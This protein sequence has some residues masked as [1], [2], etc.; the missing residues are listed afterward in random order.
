[1]SLAIMLWEIVNFLDEHCPTCLFLIGFCFTVTF[2]SIF[3]YFAFWYR[4][5]TVRSRYVY[6]LR[7]T[8]EQGT[9]TDEIYS[10]FGSRKYQILTRG[11][12]YL[13][14]DCLAKALC[15]HRHR[16][17]NGT[18]FPCLPC[19]T[20]GCVHDLTYYPDDYFDLPDR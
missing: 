1:M 12:F 19:Y 10:Y 11:D 8:A 18:S 7:S 16:P 2:G 9:Q 4:I 6:Q 20:F 14:R 3:L 17:Y 15:I 5:Y 13:C